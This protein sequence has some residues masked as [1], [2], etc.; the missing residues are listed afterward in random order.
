MSWRNIVPYFLI[1]NLDNRLLKF[2]LNPL[3]A[4]ACQVL[5]CQGGSVGRPLVSQL[6]NHGSTPKSLQQAISILHP[7]LRLFGSRH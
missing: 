5:V 4:S 1:I 7:R 6:S 2:D 3:R